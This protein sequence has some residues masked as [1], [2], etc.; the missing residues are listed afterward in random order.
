MKKNLNAELENAFLSLDAE[1]VK[2]LLTAGADKNRHVRNSLL[3]YIGGKIDEYGLPAIKLLYNSGANLNYK[4]EEGKTALMKM[5]GFSNCVELCLFEDID[6]LIEPVKFVVLHG[7][8]VNMRDKSGK[9]AM[10]YSL[11][12]KWG[13]WDN[14]ICSP[15]DEKDEYYN[16]YKGNFSA[17]FYREIPKVLFYGGAPLT[18]KVWDCANETEEKFNQFAWATLY[19]KSGR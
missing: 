6:W 16:D 11:S 15:D 19:R 17:L 1:R 5:A 18:Q 7:A 2:S 4:D 3:P 12:Q 9:N 14:Y 13:E 8:N 10:L